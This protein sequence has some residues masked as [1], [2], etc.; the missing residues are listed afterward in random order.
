MFACSTIF[1]CTL[2]FLVVFICIL[3]FLLHNNL[4]TVVL[5]G[6][7][8]FDVSIFDSPEVVWTPLV[9]DV[10]V[11]SI[12]RSTVLQIFYYLYHNDLLTGW[13]DFEYCLL[14]SFPPVWIQQRL[15]LTIAYCI[16]Q[17][18]AKGPGSIG[19]TS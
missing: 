16:N 11:I 7:G 15:R 9:S 5:T 13:S 2:L 17:F 12:Y 1:V 10:S 19:K 14:C 3:R 8:I 4:P 6:C 18:Y